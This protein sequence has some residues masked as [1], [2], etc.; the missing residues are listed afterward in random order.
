M[1]GLA[2]RLCASLA[3]IAIASAIPISELLGSSQPPSSSYVDIVKGPAIAARSL[4]KVSGVLRQ[5]LGCAL[6]SKER[7]AE[8]FG[9]G[10]AN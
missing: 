10:L 2:V 7:W 5:H 1:A 8:R 9:S 6:L 4:R 3:L